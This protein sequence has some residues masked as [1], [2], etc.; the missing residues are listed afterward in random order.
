MPS[1]VYIGA[2]LGHWH[3]PPWLGAL[4]ILCILDPSRCH[5]TFQDSYNIL[6]VAPFTT[7]QTHIVDTVFILA[8]PP[9]PGRVNICTLVLLSGS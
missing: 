5:N 7:L 6:L 9:A 4:V 3:P 8:V 2:P 1:M